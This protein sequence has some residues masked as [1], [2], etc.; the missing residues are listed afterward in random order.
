MTIVKVVFTQVASSTD[1]KQINKEHSMSAHRNASV[2]GSRGNVL[3]HCL[4]SGV[5]AGLYNSLKR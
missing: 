5:H 2:V 1:N 4:H 3:Q